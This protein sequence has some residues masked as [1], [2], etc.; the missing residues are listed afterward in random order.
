MKIFLR[1]VTDMHPWLQKAIKY[2]KSCVFIDIKTFSRNF[3]IIL[4]KISKTSLAEL[5]DTS[6]QVLE[7]KAQLP[8]I[9]VMLRIA[10]V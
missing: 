1:I 3:K 5:P 2:V 9:K 8:S 4:N 7:K 10:S 6:I